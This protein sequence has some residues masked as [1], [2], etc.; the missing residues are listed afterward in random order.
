MLKYSNETK[1]AT[2]S[3]FI[4]YLDEFINGLLEDKTLRELMSPFN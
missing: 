4:Q 3:F 1:T 2:N